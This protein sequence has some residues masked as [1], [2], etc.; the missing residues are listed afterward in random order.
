MTRRL[1]PLLLVV[2][3][4]R[5]LVAQ[6]MDLRQEVPRATLGDPVTFL[7]TVELSPGQELLENA[8]RVM[9]N[10]PDGLRILSTDTLRG[11]GDRIWRG[12]IRMAFYRIGEQPVPIFGL[13]YRTKPGAPPDTL[14]GPSIRM[15][16]ASLA[17]EGNPQLKDIKP[18]IALVGPL[19]GPLAG[20]LL[21]MVAAAYW[22]W[23]RGGGRRVRAAEPVLLPR[24]PFAAALAR[25][26]ALDAAFRSSTNG[27]APF[28][29]DVAEVLRDCLLAAGA[30]PHQGLTTP[31]VGRALPALLSTGTARASCERLLGEADLVKF[32]RLRPDRPAAEAHLGRARALLQAW[33]AAATGPEVT[34]AVR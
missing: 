27:V 5:P 25:L 4:C 2:A 18:L 31:E 1:L 26:E 8:P 15:V 9:L 30:I 33:D 21:L 11:A 14:L 7:V 10:V 3:L 6:R 23:R 13:L 17:P 32:A 34:D 29:A 24:G 28:Y 22:L 19:W 20:L 12:K 16:I